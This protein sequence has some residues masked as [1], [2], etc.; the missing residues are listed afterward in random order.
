[1][2]QAK[3]P[4]ATRAYPSTRPR[5]PREPPLLLVVYPRMLFQSAKELH[6]LQTARRLSGNVRSLRH[7]SDN[8]SGSSNRPDIPTMRSRRLVA[9]VLDLPSFA[10]WRGTAFWIVGKVIGAEMA[11]GV[12]GGVLSVLAAARRLRI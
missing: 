4:D 7:R 10:G 3:R 5:V 9:S 2:A 11:L 8:Q 6:R 1:M 12:S